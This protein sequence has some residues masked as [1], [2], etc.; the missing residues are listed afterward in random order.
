MKQGN[1]GTWYHTMTELCASGMPLGEVLT[2]IPKE[3]QYI[4][5]DLEQMASHRGQNV[6]LILGNCPQYASPRL[7]RYGAVRPE[8]HT[9]FTELLVGTIERIVESALF[10]DVR[11][12]CRKAQPGPRYSH[13]DWFCFEEQK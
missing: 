1:I 6:M 2:R 13:C 5:Q 11:A 9:T 12:V 7:A 3:I 10:L 4:Y 8:D